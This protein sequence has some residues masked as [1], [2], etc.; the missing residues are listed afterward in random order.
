MK[1]DTFELSKD[2]SLA[3]RAVRL[4]A[5]G[6]IVLD[7]ENY[8]PYLLTVLAN[9]LSRGA[10]RQ[11]LAEFGIGIVEWHALALL[12]AEPNCL[13]NRICQVTSLDKAAI[14]RALATLLNHSLVRSRIV[15]RKDPR[16]RLW[17][18]TT[19]G[20]EVHLAILNRALAR[21]RVL[22]AG[23]STFDLDVALRVMRRMNQNARVLG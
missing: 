14:S 20:E 9:K 19:Q 11:Y 8:V 3:K 23:I 6:L 12:A 18:L 4:G 5:G 2:P 21:E 7:F 15:S 13:A 1:P 17:R 22:I 16:R 10:S